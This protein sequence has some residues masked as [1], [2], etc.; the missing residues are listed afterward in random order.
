LI[1]KFAS[2]R[3]AFSLFRGLDLTNLRSLPWITSQSIELVRIIGNLAPKH[4]QLLLAHPQTSESVGSRACKEP[5]MHS[6]DPKNHVSGPLRPASGQQRW[7][8][9]RGAEKE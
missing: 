4:A 9:K 8:T 3:P 2:V 7:V 5:L 1:E 6:K